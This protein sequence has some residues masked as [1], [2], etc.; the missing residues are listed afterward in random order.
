MTL[1]QQ[2]TIPVYTI[3]LP[4]Y[5]AEAGTNWLAV[6]KKLDQVI[7]ANFEGKEIAVRC[8]GLVDHPGLSLDELVSRILE[9]GTDKY[10]PKRK[11][12]FHEYYQ[13]I[14]ID[15]HVSACVVSQGVLRSLRGSWQQ[16]SSVM[17]EVVEL[18]YSGT[19]VDRGYS[20]RLDVITVYDL[21]QL[22]EIPELASLFPDAKKET[23]PGCGLN[24]KQPD[25]K[26]KALLGVVK[27]LR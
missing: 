26:Q 2:N 16:L 6:G 22:E 20:V 10:D 4:E 15:L 9:C 11:S 17:A 12:I 23:G 14:N 5:K 21:N 19:L 13:G 25:Q 3:S 27:T 18:F 1:T 24:F 7:A 8:V